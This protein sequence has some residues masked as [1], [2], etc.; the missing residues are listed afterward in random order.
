MCSGGTPAA[1]TASSTSDNVTFSW[2]ITSDISGL[3]GITTTS[4]SASS[5]DEIPSFS[6]TIINGSSSIDVIVEVVA[7][8]ENIDCVGQPAIH[9]ITIVQ[10]PVALI[11]SDPTP[12][13]VGGTID[14]IT[15]TYIGGTGTPSYHWYDNSAG[16]LQP[17]IG[18]TSSSF[19]PGVMDVA[20]T[21]SY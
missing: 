9:T 14:P 12:I 15:T 3:N 20:G 1:V 2:A 6:A 21:F 11:S 18:E 10:D 7:T 17:L 13:C 16:F 4:G 5:S 8:T 19:D